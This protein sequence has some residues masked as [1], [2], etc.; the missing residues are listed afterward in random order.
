MRYISSGMSFMENNNSQA[1]IDTKS[2]LES[3]GIKVWSPLD[4]EKENDTW[5]GYISR[6]LIDIENNCK[7]IY[8]FGKWWTSQGSIIELIVSHRLG[9]DI[10]IEQWW[11]RFIPKIMNVLFRGRK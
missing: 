7:S 4:H 11:L 9:L 3:K 8:V 6:D 5:V 10:Y 1:F 2:E